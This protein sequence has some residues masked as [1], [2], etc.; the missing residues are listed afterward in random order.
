[1]ENDRFGRDPQRSWRFAVHHNRLLRWRVGCQRIDIYLYRQNISIY[2]EER[3][4]G[5][6]GDT[7]SNP[8]ALPPLCPFLSHTHLLSCI[9]FLHHLPPLLS[10][11]IPIVILLCGSRTNAGLFSLA[12]FVPPRYSTY[13]VPFL[14]K[15]TSITSQWSQ[16]CFC[17]LLFSPI[18]SSPLLSVFFVCRICSQ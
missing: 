11:F 13:S 4:E 1:M 14:P 16:E 12:I 8:I 3:G 17:S 18:L 15:L 7:N 10:V 6:G 2:Q 9:L 5:E